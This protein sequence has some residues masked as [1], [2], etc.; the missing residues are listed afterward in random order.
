MLDRS[1]HLQRYSLA[2]GKRV[3][4]EPVPL[5]GAVGV[6]PTPE[7]AIY[8]ARDGLI[9]LAGAG[10]QRGRQD[11][12]ATLVIA[13]AAN[14]GNLAIEVVLVYG[15]GLG[16]AGS[17]WG[18][19][20]AQYG[21]ATAYLVI[22]LRTVRRHDAPL[23]PDAAGIRTTARVGSQI[24]VRTAA[25]L[26]ALVAFSPSFLFVVVGAHHFDRLRADPRARAF[27]DGAGPAAIGAVLGSIVPL[28]LALSEPWQYGVLGGAAAGEPR[29]GEVEGAPEEVHVAGLAAEL[30]PEPRHHR[31]GGDRRAPERVHGLRVVGGVHGVRVKGDDLRQLD[32]HR[33]DGHIDA[34]V[35]QVRA[36]L[37][38]EVGDRARL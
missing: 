15:L 10:Y 7:G 4:T 31:R 25:L 2:S 28:T 21:A 8:V 6:I 19:V 20:L 37:G 12:T 13:V 23:R 1:S 24:M 17:A 35:G 16:L 18:T 14:A 38:V 30:A 26:A 29:H 3:A 33:V 36:V 22:V 11:T 32:R 9:A 27:L 5:P 34:E